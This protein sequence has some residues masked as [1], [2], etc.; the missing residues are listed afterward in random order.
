[1]E[2]KALLDKLMMVDPLIWANHR[3]LKLN[4]GIKFSLEGRP[5]LSALVNCDKR[6]VHYKKGTQ[7]GLTTTKFIDSL[8]GCFYRRYEKNVIY[9]MP[10]VKSVEKL[11]KI[12][13]DPVIDFNPWLKRSVSTNTATI[14]TIN[15]RSIVFV[16]AQPQ[17]VG[18][19]QTIDSDQ[20]RSV[21]ADVVRRDEIDLMHPEM[22]EMSKQ[23]L[24]DSSLEFKIEENFGSPTFPG[25]GI[26]KLYEQ[27][28][29]RKWQIE[30]KHCGKYTCLGESFPDSILSVDGQWRRSCVHCQKEIYVIDGQW[31]ADFPDRREASYWLE[32]LLSPRA[33][34]EDIMYR[35]HNSEGAK[36]SEFMRSV[37]GVASTEAEHQLDKQTV[38][39]CCEHE[40]MHL[41]CSTETVMG[42]DVGGSILHVVIGIR[43]GRETY[44][45]LNI[46]RV[47]G[48]NEL[49]DLAKKMNVRFA[50]IDQGPEYHA[51]RDFQ[52]KEPYPIYRCQY[53]E[54]MSGAANFDQKGVVRCNRNEM[55][56][57]VHS[58]VSS[59]MVKLPRDSK[60]VREFALELTQTAKTVIENPETG[61]PKPKWIK[62]G[63]GNDHYFHAMLYFLLGCERRSPVKLNQQVKRFTRAK[64]NF[65]I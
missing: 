12:S 59:G 65:Y 19:S 39:E 14:K 51:V 4:D 55:C 63:S 18:G 17:K 38:L 57:K 47:S 37:L 56:D 13:F 26:D 1:M 52:K 15:G 62:L 31:E 23:R 33:D 50:V 45:I 3:R 2:D 41:A 5:F 28:D 21:P 64:S 20:L 49:H 10:T 11:C 16:G 42:V 34:L 29:Q 8:H 30:C 48:W 60:E 32:G 44:Q 24:N 46:S 58:V 25:F 36:L 22:I 35:Y 40:A 61:I 9:M 6:I 27:G 53:S 7:I 43:T 54:S